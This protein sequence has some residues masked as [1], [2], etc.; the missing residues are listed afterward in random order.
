MSG[1]VNRVI[2]IGDLGYDP[3]VC[4]TDEGMMIVN[5]SLATSDRDSSHSTGEPEQ[6]TEWH[7]VV[8]INKRLA[9][10]AQKYLR[11]GSRLYLEGQLQTRAW[12]DQRGKQRS[13]TNV[14]VPPY[15]GELRILD[16][17]ATVPSAAASPAD[18]ASAAVSGSRNHI[19]QTTRTKRNDQ[20]NTRPSRPRQ[21]GDADPASPQPQRCK[22]VDQPSK[23]PPRKT[24]AT[25]AAD[26]VKKKQKFWSP[27][28]PKPVISSPTPK[29]LPNREARFIHEPGGSREDYKKDSASN[30]SRSRRPD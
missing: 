11:K 29:R 4:H 12:T 5:L 16:N 24:R 3:E 18:P 9:E 26:T 8:V 21:T 30:W 6:R 25:A 17:A 20:S 27:R 10:I 28:P 13:T 15:T 19:A 22:S 2:L 1:S 7:R 23:N 14:L